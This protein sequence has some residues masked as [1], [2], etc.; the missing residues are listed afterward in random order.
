MR[1]PSVLFDWMPEAGLQS[2]VLIIEICVL[3]ALL[4]EE[5]FFNFRALGGESDGEQITKCKA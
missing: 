1:D 3:A 4:Q 5:G 2:V